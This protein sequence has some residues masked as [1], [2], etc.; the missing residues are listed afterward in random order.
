MVYSRYVIRALMISL[1]LYRKLLLE[2]LRDEG[3]LSLVA[4]HRFGFCFSI[5]VFFFR[6][7]LRRRRTYRR[8][9]GRLLVVQSKHFQTL[10]AE[11]RGFLFFFEGGSGSGGG[12]KEKKI[13]AAG[14]KPASYKD[15]FASRPFRFKTRLEA[16]RRVQSS[17]R[18]EYFYH[19]WIKSPQRTRTRPR[20][21]L[22][23]RRT[24][25]PRT[26]PKLVSVET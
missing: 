14:A 11:Q 1:S 24:P 26:R 19:P 15:W 18:F 12:F 10:G 23:A 22:C 8:R 25:L 2:P 6:R 3:F 9:S 5:F 21:F 17:A 20:R 4:H 13:F 16:R 7:R